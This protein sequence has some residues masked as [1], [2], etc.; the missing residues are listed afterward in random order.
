[1]KENRK[2]SRRKKKME[3]PS[4]A[5]P[6]GAEW[7][8][9]AF[10]KNHTPIV[11][12]END[13]TITMA[14][15]AFYR[16]TGYSEQEI[17]GMR[18]S[19]LIHPLE[20]D[21]LNAQ[22]DRARQNQHD[23]PVGFA[24]RFF[25]KHGVVWQGLLTLSNIDILQRISVS[26]TDLTEGALSARTPLPSQE[27]YENL[28]NNQPAGIYR[29]RVRVDGTWQENSWITMKEP[30]L[31]VELV[32]ARFCEILSIRLED[33]I[34]DPKL[35]NDRIHPEDK[36]G[37]IEK[38]V[39]AINTREKFSWEGRVM[40]GTAVKWIHFESVPNKLNEQEIIWTGFLY[41]I[42][43]R[44]L[45]EFELVRREHAV[46][47]ILDASPDVVVL[48]NEKGEFQRC[49]EKLS[50]RWGKP[51][52]DIIGQSAAVLLP[53]RIFRNR[54]ERVHR[55]MDTGVSEQFTDEYNERVFEIAITP[56]EEMDG[57]V[58]TVAMFSRDI[59]PAIEA[60]AILRE[61][62]EKYRAVFENSSIAILLT[63]P[64]GQIFSANDYACRLF[65]RT[66]EEICRVGR[67]KLVDATDPRLRGMLEERQR[68][69]YTRGEL[70]FLRK[71]GSKFQG[72]LS[73][74]VFMDKEGRERTSMVI[75]D[76]TEQRQ[77]EEAL[78]IKNMAVESSTNAIGLAD[79]HGKVLYINQAYLDL[80]GFHDRNQVVGKYLSRYTKWNDKVREIMAVVQEKG[81]Y[82]GETPTI[83]RDKTPIHVSFSVNIVT[84]PDGKPICY[85]AM[86][87]DITNRKRAE[88]E[89]RENEKRLSE[90][91]KIA[92]LGH[93]IWNVKTGE[94]EWSEE[95]YKI[96]QIDPQ[97][98]VPKIDSILALSPWPEDQGRGRELIRK[99]MESHEVG[100]YEQRF[101]RPDHS[102]GHYISSFRGKY[103][104]N[105]ELLF[106]VGT[107]QDITSRK[108]VEEALRKSEQLFKMLTENAPIGIF[109]TDAEGQTTYVNPFW[110]ALSTMNFEEALG[111]G[112]LKAVHPDDRQMLSK[113]WADDVSNNTSSLAEYR[114]LRADGSIAWV[115]GK[116]VPHR[117]EDGLIIGY[118][119][120]ISDV[121]ERKKMLDAL[122]AAKE[123]AIL[124][125]KK[126]RE[127]NQTLEERVA[128]RTAELTESNKE[129]ESFS[130]SVS[131]DLRAP[132]RAITGFANI[133]K[134][135]YG[136]LLDKEG[137]RICRIISSNSE[138]MGK[139]ID[140]LL[141]FSRLG[142]SEMHLTM[143]DM[144]N[145]VRMIFQELTTPEEKSRIDLTVAR[146]PAA[147]ADNTMIKQ[148]W[149][150][151]VSNAIKYSS[152]T[153]RAIIR[154]G[155]L[156]NQQ[157]N[158]FYIKD[159]GIGFDMRYADNLFGV[160]QRL[161][162]DKEFSGTGVGLAIV[163]RI[164]SKHGGRVWAK[165]KLNNG[166]TFY[167]SLPKYS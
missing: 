151:L 64:D 145:M 134:E 86:F 18:L 80:W 155:C 126:I 37:W 147:L 10:E 107:V 70:T 103:D 42:S 132:L 46:Q 157:E 110:C 89:L 104:E 116:A 57:T 112:W 25:D 38:N 21:C 36:P 153:D 113:I 137:M 121:T 71:D 16:I 33:F 167:F 124:S 119:G 159:N 163:K 30:F 165:G 115:S 106:I 99:A 161:H 109:R 9:H 20:L 31:V 43:Q 84:S 62:E 87:N 135:D 144:G 141:A 29:I 130:Y 54:M 17:G 166:A 81:T 152:R 47:A 69:G 45:H 22:L 79:L 133:L 68:T 65:G 34:R 4:E 74:V 140:D 93:W 48:I 143:I 114:F 120:T 66:E 56:V 154:I 27:M 76:L 6:P 44:K 39:D 12:I 162:S 50:Q 7:Y 149:I 35:I 14:N 94:V 82:E 96:F 58:K 122:I 138:K 15:E 59:T 142:R 24:C 40:D 139:L 118:I 53:P 51:K 123:K 13:T 100:T 60:K 75:R 98:F 67:N 49:N 117:D 125:E 73:S 102:I 2:Y 91:Q 160:F 19:G 158:I 90:I 1:M 127:F 101:L 23:I 72:E 97:T 150:N 95:V 77:A 61:N 32:N 129:L 11:L 128:V 55:V 3:S 85:M 52:E 108:N 164:I 78:W 146:M 26:F 63:A 88:E 131:H 156:G 92:E 111:N 8:R 105:G 83:K 41:D 5:P 28:V 136:A 148:V